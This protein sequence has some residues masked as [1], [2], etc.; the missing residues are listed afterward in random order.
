MLPALRLGPVVSSLSRRFGL[1]L[2]AHHYGRSES[3]IC[4][5]YIVYS[6]PG[7]DGRC[8]GLQ[9]WCLRSSA[10]T[11]P[12][13]PSRPSPCARASVLGALFPTRKARTTVVY[14]PLAL[15]FT[16]QCWGSP[17]DSCRADSE[18]MRLD[19]SVF[20]LVDRQGTEASGR[21]VARSALV[22]GLQP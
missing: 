3:V 4:S 18:F 22:M 17:A 5:V 7:A 6:V 10:S 21:R 12:G 20:V 14:G 2:L 8:C 19:L 16:R 13:T 9:P 15:R 11:L 1:V